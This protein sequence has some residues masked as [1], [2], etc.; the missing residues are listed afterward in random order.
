VDTNV[1]TSVHEI[2]PSKTPSQIPRGADL[3]VWIRHSWQDG[4]LVDDLW[5]GDELVVKTANTTY[6]IEV[7][8]PRNREVI[9]SGGTFFRD[10][11]RVHLDG[12]SLRGAF[13]KL[14][15]IYVG[16]SLELRNEGGVVITSPV[17]SIGF[18]QHG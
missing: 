6:L 11:S 4:M 3:D 16:F 17:Q 5:A 13:L 8:S 7:I 1:K 14:G 15:G 18:V 12:C 10:R 9:I 2:V